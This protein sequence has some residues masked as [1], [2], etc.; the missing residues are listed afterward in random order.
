M[1]LH[2]YSELSC[3]LHGYVQ[4]WYVAYHDA[5][6]TRRQLCISYAQRSAEHWH[7]FQWQLLVRTERCTTFL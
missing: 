1:V 5:L 7:E 2:H 4:H 3:L 6:I